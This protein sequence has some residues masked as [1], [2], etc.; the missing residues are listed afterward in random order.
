MTFRDINFIS[1]PNIQNLRIQTTQKILPQNITKFIQSSLQ[2]NDIILNKNDKIFYSFINECNVY[3]LYIINSKDRNTQIEYNIFMSSSY[4]ESI[5]YEIYICNNYFVVNKNNSF[6]FAKENKNYEIED[7]LN[8]V[9]FNYKI[10]M[11]NVKII[12]LKRLEEYKKYYLKN[13]TFEEMKFINLN[14]SNAFNYYIFYLISLFVIISFVLMQN[15]NKPQKNIINIVK[16]NKAKNIIDDLLKQVNK[17]NIKL[18]NITYDKYYKVS[19]KSKSKNNIY[20]FL[21]AYKNKV[22]IISVY[23]I[24]KTTYLDIKIDN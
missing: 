13:N 3:E 12:T 7:I 5:S 11:N 16:V 18:S 1:H 21:Q 15:E 4:D 17:Y 9:E 19:L 10:K 6:Y 20:S 14:K 23:E 22:E 2:L 8:Y 24:K